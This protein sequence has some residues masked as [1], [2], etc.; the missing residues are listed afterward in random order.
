MQSDEFGLQEEEQDDEDV[1]ITVQKTP[2]PYAT[3]FLLDCV[4]KTRGSVLID[5][6]ALA[7]DV[8]PLVSGLL[9]IEHVT[10]VFLKGSL[11]TVTQDGSGQWADIEDAVCE[12]IQTWAF[13]HDPD[14]EL[15]AEAAPQRVISGDADVRKLQALL[16]AYISPYVESHG[17][18]VRVMSYDSAAHRVV[19]D[20]EG[21][22]V[23]CGGMSGGT[24]HAIEGLLHQKVDPHMMVQ[25]ANPY[26]ETW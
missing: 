15:E 9:S 6:T 4:V 23:G 25:V 16:D 21:S 18:A 13:L 1:T 14:I 11:I 2:H 10:H 5:Q 20:F 19:L 12:A 26:E 17:G 8:G 7:R 24:L 22:C 3:K